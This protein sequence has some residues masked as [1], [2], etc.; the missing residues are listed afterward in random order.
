M[1]RR[2]IAEG[3][4]SSVAPSTNRSSGKSVSGLTMTCPRLPWARAT[5][6]TRIRSSVVIPEINRRLRA[7]EL[8]GQVDQRAH[9]VGRPALP[10][11]HAAEIS[12]RHRQ[13][14]EGLPPG[15]ALG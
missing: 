2:G 5:R 4:T 15:F 14:D 8:G 7:I 9:R 6:P 11:D 13:L 12:R 10:P 1:I 3:P